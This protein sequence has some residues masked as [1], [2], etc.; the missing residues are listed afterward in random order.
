MDL[1]E[2]GLTGEAMVL[3]IQP[4]TSVNP[5][6]GKVV[7]LLDCVGRVLRPEKRGAIP[8][9]FDPIL[10]RLSLSAKGLIYRMWTLGKL[11][12]QVDAQETDSRADV[13]IV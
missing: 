4:C 1:P 13:L 10:H 6:P 5:G 7:E 8:N 2:L 3:D 11:D 12:M 9:H